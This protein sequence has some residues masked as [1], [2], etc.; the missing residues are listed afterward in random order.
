MEK[1]IV[2]VG[3]TAV[4]K[5]D[6]AISIAK[7]FNGEIINGDSV[8]V[9]KELNIGSAKIDDDQGIK[10]HLLDY[11]EID[12]PFDVAR[13]QKQ[14][15]EKIEE[16]TKKGKTA[17]VVGGTGLYIKALLYDYNFSNEIENKNNYDEYDNDTL[18]EMLKKIDSKSCEKIHKNNRKRVIRALQIAD[19]GTIKSQQ[20]ALQQHKMLYNAYLIGLT[21]NRQR[22]KERIDY[23]VD[24]MMQAGLEKEVTT[25]FNKYGYN[26]RPFS[27]I[28]YKEFIAYHQKQATLQECVDLVKTHTK[29]FAKRQYTWFNNQMSVNWYDIEEEGYLDKIENDVKEFL[30]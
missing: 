20:E 25:L 6:L 19:S 8:Q 9:Y 2:I 24:L 13:F 21:M 29:Q 22:L 16:I 12:D 17:I 11:L 7:H 26:K 28:G 27:A 10:H 15:R 18:Y 1:V 23:R 5:S 3:P 4:G 30:R 14:A